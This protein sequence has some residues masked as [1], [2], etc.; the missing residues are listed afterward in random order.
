MEPDAGL[1]AD[2]GGLQL[3]PASRRLRRALRPIDWVVLEDVALD[4]RPDATGRLVAPTSARQVAEHLGLSPG[5]VAGAL[6]RLRS[7]DLVTHD[8]Q[9]GPAG[10]FGLSAYVLGPVPGLNVLG[11][12][13]GA[14]RPWP[15]MAPPPV[16]PPCAVEP[17]VAATDV[18]ESAATSGAR[19]TGRPPVA[20]LSML[21]ILNDSQ[22]D[23]IPDQQ[24]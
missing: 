3:G 7:A 2:G 11:A 18:A 9:V 15:R 12:Q 13:D 22:P 19:P 6:A 4:A 23:T 24:P 17:Y 5:A 16:V 8:R 1:T 20:Q 14:Q 21:D 10:R